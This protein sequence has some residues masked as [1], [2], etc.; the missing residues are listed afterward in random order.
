MQV[1]PGERWQPKVATRYVQLQVK[2]NYGTVASSFDEHLDLR[3]LLCRRAEHN[4]H[5]VFGLSRGNLLGF[6][7][8]AL[9]KVGGRAVCNRAQP[10]S[11]RRSIRLPAQFDHV[12][13]FLCIGECQ[14][15]GAKAVVDKSFRKVQ[16]KADVCVGHIIRRRR[17]RLELVRGKRRKFDLEQ[18]VTIREGCGN[19]ALRL[20]DCLEKRARRRLQ[21]SFTARALTSGVAVHHRPR[22]QRRILAAH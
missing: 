1:F 9:D 10:D 20:L 22:W 14:H 13:L 6:A 5:S 19:G 4:V 3:E 8:N 16:S 21:R 2:E 17:R 7:P 15:Y 12:V 18:L 11:I